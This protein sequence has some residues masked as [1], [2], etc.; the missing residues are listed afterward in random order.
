M[1]NSKINSTTNRDKP[2]VVAQFSDCHLFSDKSALHCGANVF[3]HL[4][5]VL[6][7]IGKNSSIDVVIFTGDLTQDHNEI[8]YQNFVEA[9]NKSNIRVPIYYLAG[10]HDDR[11]LLSQFLVKGTF[12]A[13]KKIKQQNWQ[14]L[15]VGS[16]SDTPAGYVSESSLQ[17]LSLNI[18][19][20]CFQLLMMH[21]HPIDVGYFIDQH[22]LKN[23][24]AFWQT[25]N[26]HKTIKAIACGHVHNAL[27][28]EPECVDKLSEHTEKQLS[29]V[30][31]YTC[32]ATSIQFDPTSTSVSALEKP[33]A[34][35]LF[36]L[37]SNGNIM[38][39]VISVGNCNYNSK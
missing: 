2:V 7:D 10:N 18:E 3:E 6:I 23:K 29:T 39:K 26:Q 19:E 37:Y 9:V 11:A 30:P 15:L 21:H 14:I 31:L 33:P 17:A 34:Y 1:T 4:T 28:L 13:E 36:S 35:R 20:N 27:T 8:S 25:V 22:G 24:D 12:C 32:P 38:T 5:R 16:K